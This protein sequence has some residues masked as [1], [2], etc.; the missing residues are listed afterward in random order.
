MRATIVA[1]VGRP[2]R[3][4]PYAKLE[5][6]RVMP[7]GWS[8]GQSWPIGTTGEAE[9]VVT[10]A[11]SLWRFT[12]DPDRRWRCDRAGFWTNGAAYVSRT[13]HGWEYGVVV[14]GELVREDETSRPISKAKALAE[15]AARDQEVAR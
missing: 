10:S 1:P 7:M 4:E 5:D 6:G 2:G 3:N 13:R 8:H 9:Y 11:A 14:D 12:P 15:Q